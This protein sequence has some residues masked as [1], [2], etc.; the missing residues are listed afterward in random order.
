[1][2]PSLKPAEEVCL[3]IADISGYTGYLSSSELE[4]A[5][6]V[7][8]DF[9]ETVISALESPFELIE[10]EG[11]A[12]FV[13]A[14]LAGVTGQLVLD[15]VD[16]CYFTF[17]RHARSVVIATTCECNACRQIAALD[18]K[19]VVHTG[20]VVRSRIR[21]R[22]NVTGQPVIVAHRLLKNS[23]REQFGLTGY[24]LM[25]ERA[26]SDLGLDEAVLHYSR[27]IEAYEHL[28][29]VS[30]V[31]VDLEARWQTAEQTSAL[32]VTRDTA[33]VV[34]ERFIPAPPAVVWDF[35][36]DPRKRPLF[37]PDLVS[38]AEETVAGRREVGT[39]S[40][41]AHGSF[42]SHHEILE[43]RPFERLTMDSNVPEFGTIRVTINLYADKVGT[44]V[45]DLTSEMRDD[46]SGRWPQLRQFIEAGNIQAYANLERL[47]AEEHSRHI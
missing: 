23:I 2:L 15:I 39:L 16:A 22:E 25:T 41:C 33:A 30:T 5:Q 40:H 36:N 31:A 13:V 27:S 3:L 1:M 47:L 6:D 17:R 28:G 9:V 12:V 45:E 19:F 26:V 18:L 46:P 35:L 32:Q 8:A 4:H 21:H 24:L 20:A 14:P 11:D 38:V 37:Q 29:E 7:M 43:W 42:T 10:T 34:V 44:R